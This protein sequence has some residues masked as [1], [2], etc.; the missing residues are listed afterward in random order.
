MTLR[1]H[2]LCAAILGV[3]AVAGLPATARAGGE[4]A[5]VAVAGGHAWVAGFGLVA[6][7]DL[8]H[9]GVVRRPDLPGP[10]PYPLSIAVAGG[11]VWV[12][13]VGNGFVD[14][15][16][17]RI[18]LGSGRVRV[19]Y[20]RRDRSVQQLAGGADGIWA[21]L[22][23]PGYRGV[24]RFSP[25][26][27]LVAVRS[28]P[29][30]GWLAADPARA[31]AWLSTGRRV[32]RLG[33]RG[34]SLAASRPLG[35]VNL[36][37]AGAG[38]LLAPSGPRV[39]VLDPLTLAVRRRLRVAPL[40]TQGLP[41]D[42]VVAGRELLAVARGATGAASV[43]RVDLRTGRTLGTQRVPGTSQALA[44][45]PDGLWVAWLA[46]GGGTCGLERLDP[47]TLR[48]RARIVPAC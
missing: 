31:G 28:H 8:A 47:A 3:A 34:E 21:L 43:R 20:R 30:A 45:A 23:G 37:V 35:P 40:R 6:E 32:L 7:V 33:R 14:G 48:V 39:L 44:L 10:A 13:T 17:S 15:A 5:S 12:A 42:L 24:A 27:R 16:V 36:L 25:A 26:G 19:V 29:A 2:R 11:A 4:F 18:D 46:G 22:G 38:A 9:G 1:P 41:S